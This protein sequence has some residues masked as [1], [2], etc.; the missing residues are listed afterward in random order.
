MDPAA[1]KDGKEAIKMFFR[2]FLTL[3]ARLLSFAYLIATIKKLYS[4]IKSILRRLL[5]AWIRLPPKAT[6][7]RLRKR[8]F[9]SIIN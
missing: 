1:Y 2:S 5:Q 8:L 9:N 3:V 7:R 4:F 6:N